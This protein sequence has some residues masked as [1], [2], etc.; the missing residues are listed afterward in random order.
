[1]GAN[2]K[3]AGDTK[4][5]DKANKEAHGL[6]SRPHRA[7]RAV[8][9]LAD[10]RARLSGR[11]EVAAMIGKTDD[12]AASLKQLRERYADSPAALWRRRYS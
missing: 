4:G 11:A 10:P 6:L 8:K 2:L 9:E 3:T 1:M 12:A 5:A 7:L